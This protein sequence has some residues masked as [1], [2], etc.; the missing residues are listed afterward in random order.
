MI[1]NR[2]IELLVKIKGGSKS[3]K[4]NSNKLFI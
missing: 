2:K 1:S 4:M 3:A